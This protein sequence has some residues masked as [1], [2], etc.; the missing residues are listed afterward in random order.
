[1][2]FFEDR[3]FIYGSAILFCDVFSFSSVFALSFARNTSSIVDFDC[4]TF[5]FYMVIYVG[6]IKLWSNGEGLRLI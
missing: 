4:L 5:R 6:V 2:R 3:W 1:M